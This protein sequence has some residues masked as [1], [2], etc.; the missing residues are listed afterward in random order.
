MTTEIE[1]RVEAKV[2][3]ELTAID[4]EQRYDDM[5]DECYSFKSVGGIFAHMLPSRVLEEMDPIAYRCGKNDWED[6]ESQDQWEEI[7][8]EY[9]DRDEVQKIRDADCRS[10]G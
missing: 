10:D 1:R 5:L 6:S 9:Y 7:D 3:E 4:T 2:K 8:G